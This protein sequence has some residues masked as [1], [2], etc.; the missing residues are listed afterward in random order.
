MNVTDDDLRGKG[1]KCRA[2]HFN[3]PFQLL[4]H[5]DIE[6]ARTVAS[7]SPGLG[8]SFGNCSIIYIHHHSTLL[9][10]D[11]EKIPDICVDLFQ[12][13]RSDGRM[14]GAINCVVIYISFDLP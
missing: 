13:A 6:D 3:L 4:I 8:G 7:I 1:R 10:K 14:V 5:S 11:R 12:I 2:I 9:W